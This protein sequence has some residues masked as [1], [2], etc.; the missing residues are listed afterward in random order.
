MNVN[1][2][3]WDTCRSG[4]AR[5]LFEVGNRLERRGHNV[6][7][8]TLGSPDSHSWFPLR[9]PQVTYAETRS[10]RLISGAVDRVLPKLR[11]QYFMDRVRLLSQ[12]IPED[13]DV[14][15]AT[16]CFTAFAVDRSGRGTPFYYVQHFEPLTLADTYLA[17]MALETYYLRLNRLVVSN[18]LGRVVSKLTKEEPIYVGNGVNTETF[19]PRQVKRPDC[20]TVGTIVRGVAWK[21][22]ADVFEAM[23]QVRREKSDV[24]LVVTGVRDAFEKLER[25]YPH[26]NTLFIETPDDEALVQF[27]SMLDVFVLGSWCEGF[28]LP[29][30]E[31]MACGT[32]VVST[33]NFGIRDYALDGKN[34]IVVPARNSR[35][36]AE[37]M[38][39]VL[40]D[41]NLSEQLE[42]EGLETARRWS[43]E[44]VV[45]KLVA[46]FECHSQ[47]AQPRLKDIAGWMC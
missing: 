29:P 11:M 36:L 42:N 12:A 19:H 26:L 28:G 4:G 18:W 37:G 34:A 23:K 5:V 3:M 46:A 16:Y 22:E 15:I 31:A 1:F 38:R 35:K 9:G 43:F 10:G 41:E 8:T 27:Y 7:F 45:D 21:G 2:V 40:N 13:T 6:T 32:P 25:E 44:N 17:N 47:S 14:N 20:P 30:L 39:R 24:K 33:D